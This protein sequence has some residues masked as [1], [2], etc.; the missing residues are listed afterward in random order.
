M[1]HGMMKKFGTLQNILLMVYPSK[2]DEI[3]KSFQKGNSA[4]KSTQRL[5]SRM[6]REF[7]ELDIH[8]DFTHPELTWDGKE[9]TPV[10]TYHIC[11]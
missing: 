2:M 4:K 11:R 5:L 8:E 7:T 10:V 1:A 6:L 9:I 3:Q